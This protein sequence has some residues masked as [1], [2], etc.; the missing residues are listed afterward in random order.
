MAE[1][2]GG[3]TPNEASDRG[4]NSSLPP[5]DASGRGPTAGAGQDPRSVGSPDP[6]TV[7]S[8][9]NA[10][11]NNAPGNPTAL[12]GDPP[13]GGGPAPNRTEDQRRAAAGQ[14]PKGADRQQA[15]QATGDRQGAGGG[16]GNP[17]AGATPA[18]RTAPAIPGQPDQPHVDATVRVVPTP[19]DRHVTPAI[20]GQALRVPS[21]RQRIGGVDPAL[22]P[23]QGVYPERVQGYTRQPGHYGEVDERGIR[24]EDGRPRGTRVGDEGT[25]LNNVDDLVP[26]AAGNRSEN[27]ILLF[28]DACDR[29]GIN[30]S[31]HARPIEV[32]AWRFYG[33]GAP[34]TAGAVP[35]AVSL[36]TAGGLKLRI[37]E[38]PEFPMDPDTEDRLRRV[39][40]SWVQ[41]PATRELK[42][43]PL[44]QDMALPVAAITGEIPSRDHQ[45]PGGYLRAGGK[46]TADAREKRMEERKARLLS[47][48][49]E[50][51]Q[52]GGLDEARENVRKADEDARRQSIENR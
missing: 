28:L 42:P 40:N 3:M 24:K 32:L 39:F 44:P 51:R 50:R 46:K 8:T 48:G 47:G 25:E 20:P 52:G 26:E 12:A 2:K 11:A 41:D 16:S 21:N 10:P 23:P 35:D 30:P 27:A 36:V 31:R 7:P 33:G 38:D 1:K 4:V 29:F 45:Y 37:Y 15:P 22:I 17:L 43:A 13:L 14:P 5:G 6:Q 18:A 19:I 34:G 49:G 9:G